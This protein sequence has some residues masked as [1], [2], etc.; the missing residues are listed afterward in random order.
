MDRKPIVFLGVES[1]RAGNGGIC[2]VARLM[3]RVLGEFQAEGRIRMHALAFG[4]REVAK[5]LP[6]DVKICSGSRIGFGLSAMRHA[7]TASHFIYDSTSA[8]QVHALPFVRG[9]PSLMFIHGIEV[10]ESAQPKYIAAARRM[11]SLLTNSAFT[12]TRAE[13]IHGG[14]A[15]AELCWLATEGEEEPAPST[16]YLERPP[17]VLIV[18]RLAQDRYKGHHELIACWP[19]V[20]A[21][22]PGATLQ[23]VGTGVILDE[24]RKLAEASSA[25]EQIRFEGFV[26]EVDLERMYA[27]ARV[28]AMPSRGEGFGLVYIEAMRHRLP[29]IASIHDAAPEIVADGQTGFVVN[30]DRPEELPNRLIELLTQPE[31]AE[32]VGRAG[33]KRWVDQ[34][35]F[36]AFRQRFGHA[37]EKFLGLSNLKQ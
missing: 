18:G 21:K 16:P 11:T 10:W 7:W 4:D 3:A 12:R 22:V 15:R 35:R 25:R 32:K 17:R 9:R 37:R 28:F 34:F 24:L 13:E 30:L 5:D 36:D 20:V 33:H 26:S 6:V 14:F 23:I 8:A 29:V 2:R 19:Q 1:L 27:N 31:F